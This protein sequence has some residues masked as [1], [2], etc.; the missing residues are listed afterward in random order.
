MFLTPYQHGVVREIKEHGQFD[1]N[2]QQFQ[3]KSIHDL[4]ELTN[5]M[6]IEYKPNLGVYVP[7]F[8]W[9]KVE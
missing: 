2:N 1:S 3:P 5:E 6:I 4:C 8:K 7:G 9:S